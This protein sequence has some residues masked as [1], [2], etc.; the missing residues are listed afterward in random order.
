MNMSRWFLSLML[1]LPLGS[2]PALAQKAAAAA[3]T[4]G[5]AK[6]PG[7]GETQALKI[8]RMLDADGDG[9]I[10]RQEA[11]VGFRLKPSLAEDFRQADLNGDGYLTEQEIRGVAERRRAERQERRR[12]EQALAARPA[13]ARA[14]KP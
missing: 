2:A 10:S 11:Q 4:P 1:A 13:N 14:A 7:K 9:R 8:F 12:K 5:T 6:A 3:T